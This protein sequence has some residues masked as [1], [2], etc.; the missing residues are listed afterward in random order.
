MEEGSF[1]ASRSAHVADATETEAPA[2]SAAWGIRDRI[3]LACGRLANDGYRPY[4][5]D[6]TPADK[7]A[8]FEAAWPED[9]EPNKP[10]RAADPP[11]WFYRSPFGFLEMW[12][13]DGSSVTGS[14]PFGH[15]RREELPR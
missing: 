5:L 15:G 4:R 7:R 3:E 13:Q 9:V 1:S 10:Y 6:L 12:D 14:N 11:R 8:L 2:P